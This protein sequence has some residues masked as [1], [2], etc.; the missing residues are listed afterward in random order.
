MA[1]SPQPAVDALT[2]ITPYRIHVSQKYLDLT[3]QKLELVRLPREARSKY[4]ASPI[5]P[6]VSKTQLEPLIDHWLESDYDWRFQETQLNDHL[7]QFRTRV[8]GARLHFVHKTSNS[9]A[10]IPLLFIHGWPDSF[11]TVSAVIDS[12]CEPYAASEDEQSQAPSFHVVAPTI[13]GF[14]FSEPV[15]EEGNNLWSTAEAFDALMKRLGY[16]HYMV[17]GSDWGFKIARAIALQ[18]PESCMA[19]HTTN[20]EMPWPNPEL[21][22]FP[23]SGM[24][25]PMQSIPVTPHVVSAQVPTDQQ[26]T[27]AFALCDSPSGLLAYLMDMIKPPASTSAPASSVPT[28]SPHLSP[29]AQH[30][31]AL[32][33]T[34]Q[35][36]DPWSPTNL[37]NWT[38]LHWLP[39][40]EISLRWVA[41]STSMEPALWTAHSQVP[42]GITH[43]SVPGSQRRPH[44]PSIWAEAYH[45]VAMIRRR[46]GDVRFAAW[47]RPDDVVADIRELAGLLYGTGIGDAGMVV[48]GM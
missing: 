21:N 27:M 12:L 40:P 26:Q 6:T 28:P 11:I 1:A 8:C 18:H 44:D 13:P 43:Y 10:A 17:Y 42:L 14:G 36:R 38:M 23:G 25:S 5:S 39:G 24:L 7:P 4:G 32:S 15:K 9:P 47:E 33:S 41:N 34:S 35:P 16:M 19:V 48:R 2:A 45:R 29:Y 31:P 3:R 46:M 20:P 22:M 30:S 37:I